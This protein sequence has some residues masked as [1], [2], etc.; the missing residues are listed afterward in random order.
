MQHGLYDEPF[1]A[2]SIFH[3]TWVVYA[4][5]G[6][7]GGFNKK[8]HLWGLNYIHEGKN[9]DAGGGQ[10]CVVNAPWDGGKLN[11][12][13]GLSWFGNNLSLW[14]VIELS[15]SLFSLQHGGTSSPQAFVGMHS[16]LVCNVC[17][18]IAP[19]GGFAYF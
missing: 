2:Y 19:S 4:T 7:D 6:F 14:W 12:I 8:S 10:G 1:M 17:T 9:Y 13:L 5:E 15:G 3:E 18:V 16:I 11:H